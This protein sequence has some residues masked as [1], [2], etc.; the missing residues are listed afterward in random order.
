MRV[1]LNVYKTD[2][3]INEFSLIEVQMIFVLIEKVTP[4]VT[5]LLC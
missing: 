2:S 3:N 4:K 1:D 5:A